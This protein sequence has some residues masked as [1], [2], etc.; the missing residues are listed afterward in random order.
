M[1]RISFISILFLFVGQSLFAQNQSEESNNFLALEQSN[2]VEMSEAQQ[3]FSVDVICTPN[4]DYLSLEVSGSKEL[5]SFQFL[6]PTGKE[7]YSGAVRGIQIIDTST[8]P[9]GTYY[10]NCGNKRETIYIMK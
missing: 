4:T 10:L 1:E 2:E 8:W 5:T 6:D 3:K 7:M 9:T